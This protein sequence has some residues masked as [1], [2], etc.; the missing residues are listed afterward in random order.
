M[1]VTVAK[2]VDV[3]ANMKKYFDLAA[4]GETIM[5]PRKQNKN[6]VILSEMQFHAFETA[7]ENAE[8][9]AKLNRADEQIASGKVVVKTMDEL[10]AMA[11]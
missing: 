4:A 1:S 6:V 11:E 7:R 5:I 3:R 2:Q 10:E 8:Y 9:L